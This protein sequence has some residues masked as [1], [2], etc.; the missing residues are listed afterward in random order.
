MAEYGFLQGGPRNVSHYQ[1][2]EKSC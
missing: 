1:M 2:I